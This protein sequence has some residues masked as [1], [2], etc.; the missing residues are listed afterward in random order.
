MIYTILLFKYIAKATNEGLDEPAHSRCLVRILAVLAHSWNITIDTFLGSVHVEKLLMFILKPFT[1]MHWP[2]TLKS[3]A[4]YSRKPVFRVPDMAR[5]K[6]AFSTTET[7][8][9]IEILLVP[10][11]D[12]IL[13]NKGITKALIRLRVSAGWPVPL[14]FANHRSSFFSRRSP[15]I[16]KLDKLTVVIGKT[17][18][19]GAAF[20]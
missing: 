14:L 19:I 3:I 11:L 12:M 8:Q 5:I 15:Y 18:V 13:Y 10:S 1:H 2:I 16:V 4:Y 20:P 6:P 7:S 17:M 9:K